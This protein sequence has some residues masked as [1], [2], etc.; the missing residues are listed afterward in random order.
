[1]RL[2]VPNTG[3]WAVAKYRLRVQA[4]KDPDARNLK[5]RADPLARPA[6]L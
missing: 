6:L 1:M 3:F 5:R 4:I 2:K